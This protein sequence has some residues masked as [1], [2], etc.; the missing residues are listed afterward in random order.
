MMKRTAVAVASCLALV[1]CGGGDSGGNAAAGKTFSYGASAATTSSQS[2]ALDAQMSGALALKS[3]PDATGALNVAGVSGITSDLLG[4]S[5]VSIAT[6]SPEQQR[7]L[8]AGRRAALSQAAAGSSSSVAFENQAT[9]VVSSATKVTMTGC[10][11][12]IIN[13]S[14]SVGAPTST[15]TTMTTKV[16]VDGSVS[17]DPS[18]GKLSWDLKL[19]STMTSSST[20]PA[21]TADISA[22]VHFHESGALVVTDSTI[23]GDLLAEMSAS[24]SAQGQSLSLGVSEAVS[25]DVT[26]AGA[27]AQACV[28]GGTLE[29][30][31]VWTDRGG[32]SAT[33]LPDKA[34]KVTWT[35]CGVGNIAF[36]Q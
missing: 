28:T 32:E 30:K 10:T 16:Q 35:A 17:V 19:A 13:T 25:L 8:M 14:T 33:L 21:V 23:K 27:G 12:T 36:S 4:G 15:T 3:A 29:A 11:L 1:A 22:T 7:A 26:Y 2:S 24:A 20:P 5:G 9:C 34:A 18:L 31:R 6:A